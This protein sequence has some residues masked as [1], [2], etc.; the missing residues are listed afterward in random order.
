MSQT[1]LP[2]LNCG[3]EDARKL[4]LAGAD[5]QQGRA[6]V[7]GIDYLEVEPGQRQLDIYFIAK[8]SPAGRAS[9][10]KM[11]GQLA[12]VRPA[13]V[14]VQ[15]GERVRKIVV[16]KAQRIGLR[17]R[18]TVAE[19][20]DFSDYT[21]ALEHPLLD[22]PFTA[23]AFSFKA[24]CPSRFDCQGGCDCDSPPPVP[25]PIDYM[26]K[27]FDSFKQALL[28]RL[29]SIAPNW[30]E[31]SE[32]DLGIAL[33]ELLSYA[34]DQLSY[35]QDAVANE[36]YL[37]SARQRISVRRHARLLDYQISE[38]ASA[39]AFVVAQVAAGCVI[40]AGTQLLTRR[41]IPLEGALPPLPPVLA[42]TSD[43]V[44]DQVRVDA[45]AVFETLLDAV[46]D[47]QPSP[48]TL[49]VWDFGD[50]CLPTGSTAV[51][52]E[53]DLWYD[54]TDIGRQQPWRLRPGGLLVLEEIAGVVTGLPGDA[55]PS[56]RQVVRITSAQRVIDPLFPLTVITRVEW[57]PADALSF[58]LCISRSDAE[59]E[60]QTIAVAHANVLVAD[61]GELREQ[62]WP[63]QPVF[64]GGPVIGGLTA[65]PRP[66]TFQ[67]AEGPPSIWRPLASGPVAGMDAA[68]PQPSIWLEVYDQAGIGKQWNPVYDLIGSGPF[69]LVF[70]P[71]VGNDGRALIRFG[72]GTNGLAPADGSFVQ[73]YY[74]VGRGQAGN[75][76]ADTI[77]HLLIDPAVNPPAIPNPQDILLLRNPLPAGGGADPETISQIKVS[78][79]VAF[80]SPQLRAVTEADYADVAMRYP[81]GAIRQAVAQF[82]WTG[83]WLTVYLIL[84]AVDRDDLDQGLADD[85]KQFVAGYTQ[86][87]YDLEVQPAVFVPLDIDLFV[88]VAGDR[89]RT[90]VEAAVLLALGS[91]PLPA[92][93]A[94]FFAPANFGFGQ[95]L[96]LS[97]LYAAAAAVPGVVSIKAT[98][99]SRLYDDDLPPARP[100]TAANIAAGLISA[101]S[102]EVLELDNDPSLPERGVLTITSGGGR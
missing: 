85:V 14:T 13:G 83:S 74:R 86:T 43:A 8:S 19:P 2:D 57:D 32:A 54:A 30:V 50:C 39:R 52:L 97:A 56:H 53:G 35:L 18:V 24:G 73:A 75:V 33:I 23:L 27:D 82:R 31:R 79:P 71:E 84:D 64:G 42:P 99:F 5:G 87:G 76:G 41:G 15:G 102:L 34:G 80:R 81:G 46:L 95:P 6:E 63:Q 25:P 94:G 20:G 70:V 49:H 37:G 72:D 62:W 55:D 93:Q 47:P 67:L 51:D 100:V 68:T 29:P 96:Y 61:H 89:F 38:G 28:D 9:L 65:G 12:G 59:G 101:G 44:A 92:G 10:T 7:H 21:L 90:D 1:A 3:N 45:E 77:V 4:L 88:C 22:P 91:K 11:L 16:E 40:P 36:A 98:R 60:L 78:A 26:A 69:D 17:L 58:P 48:I 66:T